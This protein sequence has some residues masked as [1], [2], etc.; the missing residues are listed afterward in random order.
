MKKINLLWFS[1]IAMP[2]LVSC[3]GTNDSKTPIPESLTT[4]HS[5][6]PDGNHPHAI[7]LGLPSGTKWACCNVGASAP[8]AYGGYYA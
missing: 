4:A 8:E 2:C 1:V 6:C 3:F 5:S 7:D